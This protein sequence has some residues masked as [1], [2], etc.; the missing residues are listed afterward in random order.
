LS[1]TTLNS[2]DAVAVIDFEDDDGHGRLQ[3]RER[4]RR[5]AWAGRK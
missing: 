5:L 1:R 3:D 4:A 2:R